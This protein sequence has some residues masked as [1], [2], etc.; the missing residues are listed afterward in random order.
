M[1][2]EWNSGRPLDNDSPR[3]VAHRTSCAHLTESACRT[4]SRSRPNKDAGG[5]RAR[6]RGFAAAQPATP[7]IVLVVPSGSDVEQHELAHLPFRSWC[8][9][10]VRAKSKE[11]PHQEPSPGGV[12]KFATDYIFMG[13]D[14]TP[15]TIPDGYD[16]LTKALF[17]NV[18][19]WKGM[20]HGCAETA[21]ASNVFFP[22]VIRK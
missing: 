7:G 18:V 17:A 5:L 22:L 11:S 2:L 21:L 19:P 16:G 1:E 13:E 12:S 14:R 3:R 10:C 15:I 4:I 20:S 6:I 8:R 9:H